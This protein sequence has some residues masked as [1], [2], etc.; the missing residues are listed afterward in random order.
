MRIHE[1][2]EHTQKYYLILERIRLSDQSGKE[3]LPGHW[4]SLCRDAFDIKNHAE[5]LF[6]DL[7]GVKRELSEKVTTNTKESNITLWKM[8]SADINGQIKAQNDR[9]ATY[10]D[11]DIKAMIYY[12]TSGVEPVRIH[13][14]LSIFVNDLV[15]KI[16]ELRWA[17]ED[18][19]KPILEDLTKEESTK[20]KPVK[21]VDPELGKIIFED[22][23][24]LFD[25]AEKW[26]I[27]NKYINDDK[28]WIHKN[29]V[30]IWALVLRLEWE[31]EENPDNPNQASYFFKETAFRETEMGQ[32]RYLTI[33]ET[34][35]RRYKTNF[36]RQFEGAGRIR[37]KRKI[38]IFKN[39]AIT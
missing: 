12:D 30:I 26:L 1:L 11:F 2:I 22:K 28:K 15:K 10:E 39:F 35:A 3:Y 34:L 6:N 20:A 19:F 17:I 21:I 18:T 38:G 27:A 24:P 16:N 33:K 36:D 32:D 25:L 14:R 23:I 5:I 4:N 8:L 13:P 7:F 31:G 29:K 37:G 9:Y